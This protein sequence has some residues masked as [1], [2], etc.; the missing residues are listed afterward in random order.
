MLLVRHPEPLADRN[1][2]GRGLLQEHQRLDQSP[3]QKVHHKVVGQVY[4]ASSSPR[5]R[6]SSQGT[7]GSAKRIAR[8]QVM[9]EAKEEK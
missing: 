1:H 4:N 6:R 2:A 5:A 9:T 7:P 8:Y 3:A